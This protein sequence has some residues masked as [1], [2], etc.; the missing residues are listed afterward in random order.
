V[1]TASKARLPGADGR[2]S[3]NARPSAADRVRCGRQ[4]LDPAGSGRLWQW[5]FGVRGGRGGVERVEESA[6]RSNTWW[7]PRSCGC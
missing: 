6:V 3:S 4:Q 1:P 7:R 5:T 2:T